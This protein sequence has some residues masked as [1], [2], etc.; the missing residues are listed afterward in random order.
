VA[1]AGAYDTCAG[2]WCRGGYIYSV[3]PAGSALTDACFSAHVL[4]FV[5]STH[6]IRYL[7]GRPELEIPARDVNVRWTASPSLGPSLGRGHTF[8]HACAAESILP[9]DQVG[10]Y[11]AG[12][13]WRINPIPACNCDMGRGCHVQGAR[14][15]VKGLA[16]SDDRS[17]A[18]A[19]QTCGTGLQVRTLRFVR[20]RQTAM[21]DAA[22]L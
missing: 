22:P 7:D 8:A 2:C 11:P 18:V 13:S 1:C 17:K 6:V 21:R 5:G 10:T 14:G 4:P 20:E 12:S 19:N 16:Y 15:N 9:V 3:C